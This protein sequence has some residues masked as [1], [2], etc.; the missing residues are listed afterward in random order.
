MRLTDLP[1]EIL[2]AVAEYVPAKALRELAYTCSILHEVA[3]KQLWYQVRIDFTRAKGVT[4]R[5]KRY[6]EDMD[7]LC[8]HK[9]SSK[10]NVFAIDC[11]CRRSNVI[12]NMDEIGPLLRLHSKRPLPFDYVRRLFISLGAYDYRF[13]DMFTSFKPRRCSSTFISDEI[14]WYNQL[15]SEVIPNLN[16]TSILVIPVHSYTPP[17]DMFKMVD[18][19]ATLSPAPIY[20]S[21]RC[22]SKKAIL[23]K[24]Q[25]NMSNLRMVE[26]D[27]TT[28]Q[29]SYVR[30]DTKSQDML[31]EFLHKMAMP[32]LENINLYCQTQITAATEDFESFFSHCKTL[33]VLRLHG[34]YPFGTDHS[35][36]PNSVTVL[37]FLASICNK[38]SK[39]IEPGKESIVTTLPNVTELLLGYS[40]WNLLPIR[41][42]QLSLPNLRKLIVQGGIGKVPYLDFMLQQY[43]QSLRDFR[44]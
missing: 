24:A 23:G 35:W 2:E 33:K 25:L 38:Q 14:H 3:L 17:A 11:F 8:I 39:W 22:R 43:S 21:T 18:Y 4:K 34:V 41:P 15:F 5:K 9:K 10:I 26:L 1:A 42:H 31:T 7:R 20:M 29:Y 40:N 12:I 44:A 13:V 30:E 36:I 19:L 28:G 37:H 27:F 32:N 16:L 6:L